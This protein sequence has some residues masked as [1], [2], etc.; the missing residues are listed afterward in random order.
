MKHEKKKY[1]MCNTAHTVYTL[2]FIQFSFYFLIEMFH[3][4]AT[5]ETK[6][7]IKAVCRLQCMSYFLQQLG[8]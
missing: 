4:P 7:N 3:I 5:C 1:K 2:H 8:V 6:N